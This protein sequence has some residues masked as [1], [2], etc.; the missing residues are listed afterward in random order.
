MRRGA[1]RGRRSAAPTTRGPT[2]RRPC[3]GPRRSSTRRDGSTR[4]TL[5]LHRVE[6]AS[7]G[8]FVFVR[9]APD[10]ADAH[11]RPAAGRRAGAGPTLPARRARVVAPDRV[12]TVAANWKVIARELQ[13]VLPLRPGAPGAVPPGAGLQAAAA[14]SELDWERGI[15]HRDGAWTFTASGTTTRAPFPGLDDDEQVRHKGELIY[16]NLMLSLSADHVAAFR[17]PARGARAHHGG[18]RVP[19]PSRR[20]RPP[21]IRPVATRWS[22]GTWSTGRTGRS[23]SRCS[24]GWRSRGFTTASTRRWRAA[25]L[26]I[27]RYVGERLGLTPDESAEP[28]QPPA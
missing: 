11:A 19:L 2:S 13:R 7:W 26:D 28:P 12:S 4:Q 5:A 9:L 27:R 18:L 10:E 23:A 22:S 1:L 8:G 15:P 20:D 21:R 14:A 16:P 17:A 25:S 24:G 6:V 3:S